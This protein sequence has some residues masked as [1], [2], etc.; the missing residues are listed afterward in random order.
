MASRLGIEEAGTSRYRGPIRKRDCIPEPMTAFSNEF[1]QDLPPKDRRYDTPV[2][3]NLVFSVFPN[4]V[5]AWVHV[6]SY[7]GYVRRRTIG[8]FPEMDYAQAQTALT[9]SRRIVAVDLQQ[10]ARRKAPRSANH[11]QFML[12]VAGAVLGGVAVALS[13]RWLIGG[14]SQPVT[15]PGNAVDTAQVQTREGPQFAAD[16]TASQDDSSV[17]DTAGVSVPDVVAD[18]APVQAALNENLLPDAPATAGIAGTEL[19]NT[20]RPAT[21]RPG[22]DASAVN[23]TMTPESAAADI[24]ETATQSSGDFTG[25][26]IRD[27]TGES[28]ADAAVASPTPLNQPD[29]QTPDPPSALVT[30]GTAA[31]SGAPSIAAGI[32][33]T[34]G[35]AAG[36]GPD[37]SS[38]KGPVA[39]D[40]APDDGQQTGPA[41]VVASNPEPGQAVVVESETQSATAPAGILPE[42][43]EQQ[44]ADLTAEPGQA[45]GPQQLAAV[46]ADG[47]PATPAATV[48]PA[49]RAQLTSGLADLEPIDTLGA[50]LVMAPGETRRVY[51]FTEARG[52]TGA[53]V[54]HRWQ[55]QGVVVTELPFV[56]ADDPWKIYSSKN[57]LAE[58]DGEWQV[59]IVAEDG[60]VLGAE[61]FQ[62]IL[63][64]P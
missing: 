29:E 8:L 43:A 50:S 47:S 64:A 55:R 46:A 19:A 27:T 25:D 26:S 39:A 14:P 59:T 6:Y 52:M 28:R 41:T 31:G 51:F 45:Q 21:P 37:D 23:R 18:Q 63:Q 40:K 12:L 61:T 3:E 22:A 34:D 15:P 17:P 30:G 56:V 24:G 9:Q 10:G 62:I 60:S 54:T 2:A 57:I 7:E 48:E 58:Q 4:G 20:Q 38:D 42:A 33:A 16:P 11:K 32:A 49:V 1:L 44:I 13:A 35:P 53:R 36:E 5:K